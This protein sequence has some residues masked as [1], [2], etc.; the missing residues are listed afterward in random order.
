MALR[1]PLLKLALRRVTGVE[2]NPPPRPLIIEASREVYL[3]GATVSAAIP[4]L[5]SL[6]KITDVP[7]LKKAD[8]KVHMTQEQVNWL[9]T[10]DPVLQTVELASIP[11]LSR[12][13][14]AADLGVIWFDIWD[15]SRGSM[16]ATIVGCQISVLG[17]RCTVCPAGMHGGVSFCQKCLHWGD[18]EVCCW[19][20]GAVCMHCAGPHHMENH[21]TLASCCKLCPHQTP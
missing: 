16:L 7:F 20:E 12:V 4:V 21:R 13:S 10:V 15:N 14:R 3:Q 9:F 18:P 6:A 11:C 5:Q 8:S 17:R 1:V 19:L 2:S